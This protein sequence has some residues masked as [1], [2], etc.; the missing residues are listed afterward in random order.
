MIPKPGESAI[1]VC[2]AHQ[3]AWIDLCRTLGNRLDVTVYRTSRDHGLVTS[4]TM[5]FGCGMILAMIEYQQ[6][7]EP[8]PAWQPVISFVFSLLTSLTGACPYGPQE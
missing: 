8:D 5:L 4:L 6:H 1:N 2:R 7:M 3:Q